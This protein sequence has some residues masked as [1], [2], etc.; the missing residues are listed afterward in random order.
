LKWAANRH[1]TGRIKLLK[2]DGVKFV[3][4]KRD[5][6][7]GSTKEKRA[8]NRFALINKNYINLP[9]TKK[10]NEGIIIGSVFNSFMEDLRKKIDNTEPNMSTMAIMHLLD[11]KIKELRILGCDFYSGGYH[12]AYFI[13]DYLEWDDNSK[14]LVRKDKK[15]RNRVGI[16]N[17]SIQIKYLLDLIENDKRI[18][19]DKETIEMWESKI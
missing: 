10:K 13:P 15:E 7:Y 14:E 11:F 1:S 17:Y 16:H 4:V 2:Q 9:K 6:I 3:I 5:P 19:I 8:I 12:P 18:N